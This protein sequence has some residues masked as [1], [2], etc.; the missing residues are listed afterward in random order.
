MYKYYSLERPVSIGTYPKSSDNKMIAFENFENDNQ[1]IKK[2]IR[3]NDKTFNA[4][5]YLLFEKPLSAKEVND[6]E[7]GDAGLV[8]KETKLI[9]LPFDLQES[10][11][12]EINK[13]YNV[14][15]EGTDRQPYKMNR[16][17]FIDFYKN[18]SLD[19]FNKMIPSIAKKYA[20]INEKEKTPMEQ[21]LDS[22]VKCT[23]PLDE[24]KV[25]DTI[26]NGE[27]VEDEMERE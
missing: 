8:K 6:Y 3:D 11:R 18:F 23:S 1:C 20:F 5:G 9:D 21:F 27:S 14:E 16:D 17:V 19:D 25:L 4:W 12:F 7:L 26:E 2:T 15:V 22:G 24:M 10:L 13:F